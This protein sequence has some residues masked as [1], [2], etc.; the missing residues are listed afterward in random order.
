MKAIKLMELARALW[1]VQSGIASVEFVLVLPLLAL[2]LF[3]TIDMGRV[4]FDYHAVSKNV[5]DATRYLARVGPNKLAV[6]CADVTN[7]NPSVANPIEDAQNLAMKGSTDASVPYLLNYWTNA[8]SI[9]IAPKCT[10]NAANNY[11]GFYDGVNPIKSIKMTAT[12][13]F[14]FLNG[15]LIDRDTLTFTISHEEVQIGQ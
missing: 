4:L 14:P 2:L 5:R 8:G 7:V 9:T 15:W 1:R 13:S 11:Q 10:D 12:V 3:G 6:T